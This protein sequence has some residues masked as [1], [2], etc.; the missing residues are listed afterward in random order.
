M[1]TF[2]RGQGKKVLALMY[3]Y[4]FFLNDRSRWFVY[5]R[6]LKY[7]YPPY[8]SGNYKLKTFQNEITGEV[9]MHAM[10]LYGGSRGIS[11]HVLASVV[12]RGEWSVAHPGR[13]TLG[14]DPPVPV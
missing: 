2:G 6:S 9:P 12:Y 1:F 10:K 3:V 5:F 13:V 11:P 14:E 4:F 8:L 7:S